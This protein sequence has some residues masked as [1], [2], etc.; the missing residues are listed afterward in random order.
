MGL[1]VPAMTAEVPVYDGIYTHFAVEENLDT[2]AGKLKEELI[3][4]KGL[5]GR[6]TK[7]SFVIINEIFTSAASYDAYIMGKK[8]MDFLLRLDCS[9]VYV[10]HIFELTKGDSRIVSMVA[11]LLEDGSN[12]R[13]FRIER[14]PAD[15][16]SYANTIV[17]KH[18]LTYKDVKERISG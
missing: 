16:R 14:R 15:G 2:G 10:T 17:E 13:T 8:V 1:M 12:I 11:A 6:I 18:R 3:R 9:G 4:F 7:H 5:M